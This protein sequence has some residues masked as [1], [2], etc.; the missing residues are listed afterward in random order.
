MFEKKVDW[1]VVVPESSVC[2]NG[3]YIAKLNT[4]PPTYQGRCCVIFP[5]GRAAMSEW[6]RPFIYK[7]IEEAE[8]DIAKLTELGVREEFWSERICL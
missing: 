3:L 2:L 5:D 6:E 1:C 4:V 7:S 8:E